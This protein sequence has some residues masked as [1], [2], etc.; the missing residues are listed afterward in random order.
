VDFPP[1]CRVELRIDMD[2]LSLAVGDF[3]TVRV[4]EIPHNR[5]CTDPPDVPVSWYARRTV[6]LD[7]PRTDSTVVTVTGREQG[8]GYLIAT[9]QHDTTVRDSAVLIV[10]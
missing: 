5:Y 3:R 7:I 6:L 4:T 2:T 9:L 10:Y 1:G 8:N